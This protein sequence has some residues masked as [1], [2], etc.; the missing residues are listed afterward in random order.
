MSGLRIKDPKELDRLIK[1]GLIKNQAEAKAAI[2]KP[3]SKKI[4]ETVFCSLPPAE[5]SVRLYRAVVAHY[6]RF[7][8]GGEAVYELT[9]P[10][11]KRK[12]RIDIG[13]PAYKLLIEVD[14]WQSHGMTLSG[15]QRDREKSLEFERKGWRVIRFSNKQIKESLPDVLQAIAEVLTH[16]TYEEKLKSCVSQTKF[17][18]SEFRLYSLKEIV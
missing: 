17:D 9:F 14:G 12:Y 3:K 18:R 4:I 8:E 6:G 1:K 5:P 16:C 10:E 2:A 11:L 13:L 15:F 7:Y